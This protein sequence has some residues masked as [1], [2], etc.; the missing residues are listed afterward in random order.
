M[1]SEKL[2]L[3]VAGLILGCP[4]AA[5]AAGP[6]FTGVFASA[7]SAETVFANPAG[8]SR[9]EGVSTTA[10]LMLVNSWS[11]FDVNESR[12]TV[13]GG[14]PR[15]PEPAI[16]PSVYYARP[17]SDRWTG[18]VS[19]NIPTGFGSNNGPNWAGRYYSD[20]F[21]L[22]YVSLAPSV[23]YRVT[24]NFSVG[25]GGQIMYGSSDV[26]TRINNEPFE[27]GAPD[28]RLRA[29]ADGV[30]YS[31]S[32]SA[33]YEFSPNTR[34]GFSYRGET[35]L[36]MEADLDFRDAI[37]PPG[38]IEGLEGETINIADTVPVIIGAGFFHRFDS[39][40]ELS[41]DVLWVEFSKFGVTEIHLKGED[42]NVPESDY[43]D[44]FTYTAGLSWPVGPDM[45][46]A[47]GALYVEQ[48]IDDQDRGFGITL[49]RVWG[50]G[51]GVEL[52]RGDGRM[53]DINLNLLDTG[54]API[55]TGRAPIRGRVAGEFK[56]HYSLTLE[57]TYHWL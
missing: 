55:D 16:I 48:P 45:R 21:S 25:L 9:L 52:D 12:T 2:S 54:E 17:L 50:I 43:N 33:L 13:D 44:F 57:F 53:L 56:D 28:G 14:S 36:D 27:P 30:G 8:M 18:G 37:R 39:D 10:S 41:V 46:L 47:V 3:A 11:K 49:D 24:D 34:V 29:E 19:F 51:A 26:K 42:I 32:L 6:A 15:D 4:L 7:D 5:Q 38:I 23:S 40:W 20:S 22:V 35:D 31:Y 1:R